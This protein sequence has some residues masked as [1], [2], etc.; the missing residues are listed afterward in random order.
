LVL[1]LSI[2]FGVAPIAKFSNHTVK[3]PLPLVYLRH[4][5]RVIHRDNPPRFSSRVNLPSGLLQSGCVLFVGHDEQLVPI[6]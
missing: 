2:S 1:A 3:L 4:C 6:D 5:F